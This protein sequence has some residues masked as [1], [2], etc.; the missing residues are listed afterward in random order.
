[1]KIRLLIT[2]SLLMVLACGGMTA[3]PATTAGEQ[4][5]IA[6]GYPE[7][8]YLVAVGLGQSE[9]EAKNRAKAELSRIFES[10][11]KS[12]TLDRML[13]VLAASGAEKFEQSVES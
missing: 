3:P 11:I 5:K 13:S 9:P 2:A 10:R 4:D 12:E 1:M 8:E 6:K 7:E